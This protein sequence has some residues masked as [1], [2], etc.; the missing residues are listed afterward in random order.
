MCVCT[1]LCLYIADMGNSK[2][3]LFQGMCVHVC[4]C[5]MYVILIGTCNLKT[6][7]IV[8]DSQVIVIP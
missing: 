4:T 5:T 8:I 3:Y 6:E 7:L 2:D 1:S